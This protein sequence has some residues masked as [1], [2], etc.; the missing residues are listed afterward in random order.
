[1]LRRTPPLAAAE[2]FIAAARLPSFK[3][4]AESL[5]LSQSAFTR[6]IQSLERFVGAPLFD[7]SAP[8]ITLTAAGAR[9][10]DA[11]A[12]AL[13][14][15]RAATVRIKDGDLSEPLR[16][17]ASRSFAIDWMM[18]RL[19]ALR[20]QRDLSIELVISTGTGALGRGDADLAIVGGVGD[21]DLFPA[22]QLIS[23]DGVLVGPRKL[24]SGRPTPSTI[25]DV[26]DHELL[27]MA[28]PQNTWQRWFETLGYGAIGCRL[29]QPFDSL[30]F[31]YEAAACGLGLALAVP[32]ASERHLRDARLAPCARERAPTGASYRLAHRS[33]QIV[34]RPAAARFRA[35]LYDEVA[36]S[37]R[38]F[39]ELT[40][41]R[42]ANPAGAPRTRERPAAQNDRGCKERS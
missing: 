29:S 15:I 2:A 13:D 1:M 38:L 25:A 10:R 40:K 18:P 36:Q 6:R 27:D 28:I 42:V 34:R 14:V 9:Y 12:P 16:V 21:I 3:A 32:L 33:P 5:A 26:G 35:W 30:H 41:G 22:D 23:L 4:A 37:A 20:E 31:M 24:V 39:D 19:A 17:S 8:A 11:I 7:R